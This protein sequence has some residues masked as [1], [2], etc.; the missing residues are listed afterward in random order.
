MPCCCSAFKAPYTVHQIRFEYDQHALFSVLCE[1]RKNALPQM[2]TVV[3][4]PKET[5]QDIGLSVVVEEC[6]WERTLV[7]GTNFHV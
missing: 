4:A 6:Q 7:D 2:Y 1:Y 3:S 5:L